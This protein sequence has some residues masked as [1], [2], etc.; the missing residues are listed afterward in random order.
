[1]KDS[2]VIEQRDTLCEV[3]TV[4]VQ[5][6]EKGD[7]VKMSTVTD[8]TRGRSRDNIAAHR[9]KIVEKTDTVYVAVRDS[10]SNT[11]RANEK[12][13]SGRTA[14]HTTLKWVFWIIIALTVLVVILKLKLFK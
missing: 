8:R 2:V 4:T 6:N 11:N 5:L 10:V 14:L 1:V 7:T 9:T 3:T 13:Q 12:N